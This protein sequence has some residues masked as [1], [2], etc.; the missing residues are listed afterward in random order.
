VEVFGESSDRAEVRSCG[1]LRVITELEFLKH[2][3]S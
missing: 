1:S 3:L 2:P